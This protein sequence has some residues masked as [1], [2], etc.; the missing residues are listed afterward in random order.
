LLGEEKSK[1]E[2]LEAWAGDLLRPTNDQDWPT[3]LEAAIGRVMH[4]NTRLVRQKKRI[5]G[6]H[7]KTYAKK[8]QLAE[9]QLQSDPSNEGVRD[10]LSDAQG[11]LAEVF[12]DSVAHN[13]HL[14]SAN[15]LRYGDTYSK[16]FF[17]FHRIGKKK[18]LLRELE[19]EYGTIT[20]QHDLT[21][22]I[23]DY[24]T[25]LYTSDAFAPSTVEAQEQCWHNVSTKVMG[26]INSNLIRNLT[27]TEIRDAIRALPKG[28]APGHNGVPM[29]FFHE[30]A[31]EVVPD[32]LKAF[33][34]M[35][36]AGETS[37]YIN[38]GLITLTPKSG[39]HARLSNWRPITLLES[40]YKILAKTLARRV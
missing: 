9:I 40:T 21:H 38:K 23:T 37:A 15:W 10:I 17:D 22:Y 20:G 11:K 39:N 27:L 7:I 36:N 13:R 2:M 6:M 14:S 8:I 1:Q 5:Q 28:K 26:D 3:W 25:R 34:A 19:T 31:K 18:A 12:R 29:E 4:S 30:F 35:L 32:L 24:Y 16:A 33:T